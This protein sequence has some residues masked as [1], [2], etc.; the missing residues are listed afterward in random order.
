MGRRNSY[1]LLHL[2]HSCIIR[3]SE[4]PLPSLRLCVAGN[5]Q[6]PGS[7]PPK[8]QRGVYGQVPGVGGMMV[9][10]EFSPRS[11]R[12]VDALLMKR[13]RALVVL[14]LLIFSAFF[15]ATIP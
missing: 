9:K 11:A 13:G 12:T 3:A 10:D 14:T 15:F 5:P 8:V 6:T 1:S 4:S 2:W 7:E